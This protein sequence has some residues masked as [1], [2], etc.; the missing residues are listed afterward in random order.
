[1][2]QS[3]MGGN[4][5]LHEDHSLR[6]AARRNLNIVVWSA[7]PEVAQLRSLFRASDR[8]AKAQPGGLAILSVVVRGT[9]SFSQEVRDEMVKSLKAKAARLGTA[10]LI[11]VDGLAGTAVRAFMSTVLLLAR[12]A[13]PHRVFGKRQEALD[14]LHGQLGGGPIPWTPA[15]LADAL[16]EALKGR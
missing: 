14:W 7:A 6:V 13:A 15:E 16:E 5:I 1:M 12:P 9:P 2:V 4:E 10:H 8:L 11:L 3:W